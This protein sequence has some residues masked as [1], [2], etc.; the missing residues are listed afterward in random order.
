MRRIQQNPKLRAQSGWAAL[1]FMVIVAVMVVGGLILIAV[2]FRKEAR[3]IDQIDQEAHTRKF[4]VDVRDDGGQ[5]LNVHAHFLANILQNK[6]NQSTTKGTDID[7]QRMHQVCMGM[8][9]LFQPLELRGATVTSSPD[10]TPLPNSE[11]NQI[12]GSGTVRIEYVGIIPTR[13][14]PNNNLDTTEYPWAISLRYTFPYTIEKYAFPVPEDGAHDDLGGLWRFPRL[15]STWSDTKGGGGS[16]GDPGGGGGTLN[17]QRNAAGDPTPT[18]TTSQPRI[19]ARYQ[20]GIEMFAYIALARQDVSEPFN[21]DLIGIIDS[22]PTGCNPNGPV[23]VIRNPDGSCS[24]GN[25]GIHVAQNFD[26]CSD[27][28]QPNYAGNFADQYNKGLLESSGVVGWINQG[29]QVLHDKDYRVGA[30]LKKDTFTPTIIAQ[31]PQNIIPAGSNLLKTQL[32]VSKPW[33]IT[34]HYW[35]Y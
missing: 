7:I 34:S 32:Y 15:V 16:G 2:A 14:I 23:E 25:C 12:Y 5:A 19:L 33:P 17:R 4:G 27:P 26:N 6:F 10:G 3:H 30:K 31:I 20:T 8:F 13:R 11:W 1:T 21:G 18:P 35:H 28:S 9:P 29:V 22:P 24:V